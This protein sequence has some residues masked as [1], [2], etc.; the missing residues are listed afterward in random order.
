MIDRLL[1][2]ED[3]TVLCM[4]LLTDL[5]KQVRQK[6]LELQG[7]VDESILID[8]LQLKYLSN[9]STACSIIL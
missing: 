8:L 6:L 1:L 3:V 9:I 7:E 2:Q 5:S 4:C